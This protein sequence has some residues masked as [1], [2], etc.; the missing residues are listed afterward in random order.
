V[1]SG[2]K[3]WDRVLTYIFFIGYGFYSIFYPLVSVAKVSEHWTEIL[4]GVEFIFA[5]AAM[6]YGL[7][8]DH[9]TTWRMGMSVA[10]IGLTTITI[11][12]SVVG[13]PQSY[14]YAF[15][16]GAFAMQS[17]YGI[18]REHRRRTEQEKLR[19]ERDIRLQLEALVAST[20]P[21]ETR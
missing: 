6:L 4:L 15:L 8:K 20:R 9:Y 1:R 12:V 2:V 21:G 11:L 7:F 3:D 18:R 14:A 16:F 5:G 17:L 19:L 13:G 10:F